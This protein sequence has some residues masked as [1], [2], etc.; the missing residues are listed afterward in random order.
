MKRTELE[1]LGLEA[2]VIEKIMIENGKD[3]ENAK[4]AS[5]AQ[6][7][8]LDTLKTQM[9]ER[10][11][12]IATLKKASTEND[13]LKT[14]IADLQSKY[15]NDTESLSTTLDKVKLDGAVANALSK[16][17]ARDVDDIKALIKLDDIK[18]DDKGELTG[19]NEQVT[20]LQES[21]AYLFDSA[22]PI[23]SGTDPVGGAANNDSFDSAINAVIEGYN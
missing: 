16:V 21:K 2:D 17:N 10:D 7:A 4:S 6:L 11:K 9:T 19:L 1:K 23:V 20:T 5:A 12:D 15:K 22:K 14:Q 8:E 3:I 18:L 13:S